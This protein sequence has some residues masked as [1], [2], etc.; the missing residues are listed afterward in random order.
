MND[1]KNAIVEM[2][3]RLLPDGFD[4]SDNAPQTYEELDGLLASGKRICVWSGGSSDTIYADATVNYAFRAWHDLCHWWGGFPFT[5]EGEIATC[6][7]QC[8]QLTVFYGNNETTRSWCTMIK[9]EV[10]GQAEYFH[11]HKRF[12][13]SQTAFFAAYMADRNT[14]LEWPLW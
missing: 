7:M 4:V 2:A 6:E 11:R 5:L 9:A 14:A 13:E 12:P 3:A 8:R 10:V 1:L